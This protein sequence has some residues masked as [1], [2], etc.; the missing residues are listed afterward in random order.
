MSCDSEQ[1]C[2]CLTDPASLCSYSM[3]CVLWHLKAGKL[4]YNVHVETLKMEV[5]HA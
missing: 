5:G 4:H 2:S 3:F 1:A